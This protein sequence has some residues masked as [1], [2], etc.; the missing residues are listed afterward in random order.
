[1]TRMLKTDL[2][3]KLR[4]I[5]NAYAYVDGVRSDLTGLR[6]TNVDMSMASGP[7]TR[8]M[9]AFTTFDLHDSYTVG[10]PS[11]LTGLVSV[12]AGSTGVNAASVAEDILSLVLDK[13]LSTRALTNNCTTLLDVNGSD[14]YG[15]A[16]RYYVPDRYFLQ[17]T[18][19]YVSFQIVTR[20]SRFLQSSGTN[21]Q[22]TGIV[23]VGFDYYAGDGTTK[24]HHDFD[25]I[26]GSYYCDL[27]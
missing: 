9:R 13:S 15:R 18:D 3:K 1:M 16:F 7:Y 6:I 22:R 27:S 26:T 12:V 4:S 11:T 10:D 24:Y 17:H 21:D 19:N 25:R 20:A 8:M 14:V 5:N 2:Q 23:E